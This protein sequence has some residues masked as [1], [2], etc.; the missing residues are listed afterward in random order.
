MKI[1]NLNKQSIILFLEAIGFISKTEDSWGHQ[2]MTHGKVRVG[3]I[4][5]GDSY[6]SGT[7]GYKKIQN[8]VHPSS[9]D[10]QK[11][12]EWK[13]NQALKLLEYLENNF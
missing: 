3:S 8:K 12:P 1:N 10:W 7:G 9:Y 13:A 2:R 4:Y 6:I 11:Y 5:V